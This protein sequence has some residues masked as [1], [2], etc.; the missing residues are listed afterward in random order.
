MTSARARRNGAMRLRLSWMAPLLAASVLVS[1]AAFAE[2]T[3][4]PGESTE[5]SAQGEIGRGEAVLLDQIAT[6]FD[7]GV[8]ELLALR[9]QGFGIGEIIIIY[10]LA[11]NA[12]GQA[13]AD[14]VAAILKLRQEGLGWGGIAAQLGVEPRALGHAVAGVLGGPKS[15]PQAALSREQQRVREE[16]RLRV[17]LT[18]QSL[19]PE[20]ARTE[21]SPVIEQL[22]I[23]VAAAATRDKRSEAPTTGANGGGQ[24][25]G[26]SPGGGPGKGEQGCCSKGGDASKGGPNGK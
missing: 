15:G 9:A 23:Q 18:V 25:A 24:G 19:L 13:L 10:S 11:T 16:E 14:Q 8:E 22:R 12:E 21:V 3:V 1:T 26:G 2:D 4:P 7:V 6:Y 17:A 20:R 5:E